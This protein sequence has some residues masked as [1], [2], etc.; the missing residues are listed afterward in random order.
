M[1]YWQD[2]SID[3]L[4]VWE[5]VIRPLCR[6]DVPTKAMSPKILFMFDT[7]N[8]IEYEISIKILERNL[9]GVSTESVKQPEIKFCQTCGTPLDVTE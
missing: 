5:R 1:N 7:L 8:D 2:K 3:E 9:Y 6:F 4:K